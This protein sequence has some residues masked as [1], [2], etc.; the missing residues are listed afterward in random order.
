MKK[1]FLVFI[2]MVCLLFINI[3]FAYSQ[4]IDN[5]NDVSITV[6]PLEELLPSPS[7]S[8]EGATVIEQKTGKVLYGKDEHKRLYPASTTKVLTGLLA[9][10]LGNLD[11]LVTVGDE[12]N[13]VAWDGSKAGLVQNEEITLENLVY[14]LLINSGNDAANTIAVHIAR[15][16]SGKELGTQEAI[17]YFSGLMNERAVKAGTLDSNFVSPHGYHDPNHYTTAYDLAM[18][19]RAAM[20]HEFFRKVVATQAMDTTY[21]SNGQPRY[22]RS[23]DKL[24]K[25]DDPEYYE[26]ATGGKTGYT[27]KAGQCLISFASKDGLDLVSVVFKSPTSQQWSD[28]RKLFGYGFSNF[29]YQQVLQKGSIVETLPVENFASDDWGSLAVEIASDDQGAVFRKQDIPEIERI[30]QWD[31][32]LL[33]PKKDNTDILPKLMAPIEQ[34]QV[35]GELTIMLKGEVIAKSPLTAVRDVKK[36]TVIDIIRPDLKGFNYVILLLSILGAYILL[37]I[38]VLIINQKRRRNYMYRR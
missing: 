6:E 33:A 2:I 23:K 21:W 13:M 12:I 5:T 19:G 24:I 1:H 16:V 22:W 15:K 30:I 37:R 10:E 14:G 29:T 34:G 4:P 20:E 38:I 27:S 25:K 31:E 9:I 28:S 11:D 3:P 7:L 17:D 36:K 26:Y 32:S 8:A 18:I 35:I